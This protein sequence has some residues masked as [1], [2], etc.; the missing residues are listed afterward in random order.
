MTVFHMILISKFIFF[1]LE[2]ATELTRGRAKNLSDSVSWRE[3]YTQY[4][5]IRSSEH[6]STN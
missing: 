2:S 4:C 3:G 6:Q 1:L 5:G